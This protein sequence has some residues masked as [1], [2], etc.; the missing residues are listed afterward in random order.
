MGQRHLFSEGLLAIPFGN[1]S[2]K[3][4]Q[5]VSKHADIARHLTWMDM[6]GPDGMDRPGATT[7]YSD[8]PMPKELSLRGS[9]RPIAS[10]SMTLL[11]SI[12]T[13]Q[14]DDG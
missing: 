1:L 12:S 14:Q 9:F 13:V 8:S 7:D 4:V 5:T 3:T 10:E 6:T 2:G 11:T